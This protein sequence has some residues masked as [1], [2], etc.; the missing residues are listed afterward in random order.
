MLPYTADAAKVVTPAAR[1]MQRLQNMQKK[2]YAYGHQNDS[3]CGITWR[4]EHGRSDTYELLGDY[5]AVMGFDIGGIEV[6]NEKSIDGIPF[7]RLREEIV[8]H[9]ERGG[10]VTI[11][12]HPKNPLVGTTAWISDDIGN[13]DEAVA[14]LKKINREDLVEKIDDPRGT[15]KSVVVGGKM[16]ARY[17]RWLDRVTNFLLSL[18]DSKGN[19]IPFIFRPLHEDNG[20]WFWWGKKYGSDEDF[21]MLWNVTQNYISSALPKTM[22]WAYSPNLQGSWTEREWLKRYPGDDRVD[23]IGV[24]AYQ[25]GTENDFV[26]QLDADLRVVSKIAREH[27]KVLAI[28]ECGY[29]NSPDAT[30]WTRVMKPV[31]D[32]YPVS[33]FLAWCNFNDQHYGAAKE[34]KTADDFLIWSKQKKFLLLKDVRKIK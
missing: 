8:R 10:I 5:P 21:R 34:A 31:L 9:H 23:L 24:D 33:Y 27:R 18:K 2:G 26:R 6:N 1:L 22:L 13:Y 14:A 29:R 30:W 12:W 19:R 32:R 28:T 16:H 4:N 11:S 25:W 20:A 17:C 7:P 3:F 15:L